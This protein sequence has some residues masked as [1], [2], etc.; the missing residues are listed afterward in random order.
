MSQAVLER[1]QPETTQPRTL[2]PKNTR[3][4]RGEHGVLCAQI[5]DDDPEQSVLYQGVFAVLAFPVSHPDTF[6]SLR[7]FPAKDTEQEIGM[8]ED[9]MGFDSATVELLGEALAG[10]YFEFQVRRINA[11]ELRW[12]LLL[13]DVLTRQGPRQFEMRW[14][15]DRT[16]DLGR[17]GKVLLDVNNN[18]FVIEDMRRLPREDRA[19]FQRYIYW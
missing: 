15:N 1:V 12:G 16:Q 4:Y 19:R 18:R 13:F 6:V 2:G 17:H 8:I 5:Q 10:H 7:Y 3:I 11:V 9:P 14:S